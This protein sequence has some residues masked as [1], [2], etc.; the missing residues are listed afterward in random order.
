[1][2]SML[3]CSKVSGSASWGV[4]CGASLWR[5]MPTWGNGCA[6]PDTPWCSIPLWFS[7]LL[8]WE[9]LFRCQLGVKATGRLMN[10]EI[11]LSVAL[12][13]RNR[14]GSLERALVSLRS[15]SV[16]PFE[17]VVSDDSDEE[18]VSKTESIAHRLNYRYI[19]GPRRLLHKRGQGT[20]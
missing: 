17:V 5:K 18:F 4:Q 1:M 8:K 6:L 9:L 14:P 15:Q 13:T 19:R 16:Q 11:L 12:I 3:R 2:Q 7:Y 10:Q 20:L